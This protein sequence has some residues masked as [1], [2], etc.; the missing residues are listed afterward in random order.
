LGDAQTSD[1]TADLADKLIFMPIT[2]QILTNK[3]NNTDNSLYN[4]DLVTLPESAKL[5]KMADAL[6]QDSKDELKQTA[7]KEYPVIGM[8][9]A[10]KWGYDS[11]NE[12]YTTNVLVSGS[13]QA[14]LTDTMSL[15]SVENEKLLLSMFNGFTGN[16][17][18]VMISSKS[19]EKEQLEFTTG[20]QNV[21]FL[22]F[23]LAVPIALLV[24]CI[25]IFVRRRRL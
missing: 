2:R 15:T 24:I 4:V 8:A 16:E 20:Q 17:S 1:F 13:M 10:A 12:K 14:F 6:N 21:F 3:E 7:A 11:N 25:V 22:I 19:L 9:Y 23:V 5:V 18:P